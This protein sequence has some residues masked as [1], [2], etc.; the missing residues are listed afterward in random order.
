MPSSTRRLRAALAIAAL[1]GA[2]LFARPASAQIKEPG[3]HPKYFV[4]LEPH[5]ALQWAYTVW[6][7][8]GI[9]VGFRASIPV[10]QNG[11]ISTINN[12]LAVGFGFDWAH[13]GDAGCAVNFGFRNAPAGW[14]CSGNQLWFPLV[15][16]WNFFFTPVVSAFGE[17]GLAIRHLNYETSCSDPLLGCRF[18]DS[19]TD[20]TPAFGVGP[21][22]NFSDAFAVTLRL[23]IP[24]LTVGA[25]FLL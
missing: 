15:A 24:Y 19:T 13:I 20:V 3:A 22:F 21:R 12:N 4:E 17:L 25:S 6:D 2:A 11:P 18:S 10:L 23:G 14:K 5:F 16:Q 8:T 7:T 9:G 1:A